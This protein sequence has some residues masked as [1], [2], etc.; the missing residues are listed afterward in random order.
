MQEAL[1]MLQK[2]RPAD[3]M[4][5]L[6]AALEAPTVSERDAAL[7]EAA[8]MFDRKAL[9]YAECTNARWGCEA[10]AKRI[11]SLKSQSPAVPPLP[12]RDAI[13]EE[14]ASEWDRRRKYGE[15]DMTASDIRSLQSAPARRMLD[16][17]EVRDVLSDARAALVDVGGEAGRAAAFALTQTASR[18][19]GLDLDAAAAKEDKTCPYCCQPHSRLTSCWR[20]PEGSR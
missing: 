17:E 1:E 12:D 5:T 7:E 6:A 2:G 18:R 8:L 3:A 15:D 4:E 9:Q 16:A 14:V 19:L 10:D 13:L 11:R 20:K